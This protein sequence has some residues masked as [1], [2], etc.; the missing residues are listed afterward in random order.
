MKN[1]HLQERAH[2]ILQQPREITR[3]YSTPA[4]PQSSHS[5]P[6]QPTGPFDPSWSDIQRASLRAIPLQPFTLK[7][8]ILEAKFKRA[9]ELS[10]LLTFRLEVV[11]TASGQR[12]MREDQNDQSMCLALQIASVLGSS[13][14]QLHWPW[15]PGGKLYNNLS[16]GGLYTVLALGPVCSL[17]M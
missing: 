17:Y 3:T 11:S 7:A 14:A 12:H 4:W 1:S 6:F 9:S 8:G 10:F 5:M 13:S 15:D 2:C 16:M